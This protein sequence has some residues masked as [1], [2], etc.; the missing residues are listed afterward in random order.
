MPQ[1]RKDQLKAEHSNSTDDSKW[2]DKEDLQDFAKLGGE[3]LKRKMAAGVDVLKEVKEQLPKE[4]SQI[5]NRGKEEILK[6]ISQETAK[7]LIHFAIEKF[8]KL[9]SEHRL[10][11]SLRI[12]RNEESSAKNSKNQKKKKKNSE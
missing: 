8:F 11:F 2:F 12:R 5:L 7:Q 4:A 1:K 10:E 9:A 6:G 3:F